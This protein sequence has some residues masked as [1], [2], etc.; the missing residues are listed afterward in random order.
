MKN[1]KSIAAGNGVPVPE[2]ELEKFAPALDALE[3]A[4]RPL[5]AAIPLEAEPAITLSEDAVDCR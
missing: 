2:G 5:V 1:W 4:F 3:A